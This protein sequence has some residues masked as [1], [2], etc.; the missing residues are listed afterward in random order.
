[1]G[2]TEDD[3][4]AHAG[5]RAEDERER[6]EELAEDGQE[7]ERSGDAHRDERLEGRAE[8]ASAEP[9]GRLLERVPEHAEAERHR[10]IAAC[11]VASVATTR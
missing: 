9:S 5:Q 7:R 11:A 6:T 1:M 4:R 2:K 3:G 10:A 8:A